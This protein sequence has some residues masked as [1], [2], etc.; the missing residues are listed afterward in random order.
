RGLDRDR[1]LSKALSLGLIDETEIENLKEEEVWNFIFQPGFSTSEKVTDISGRGVGL[2]I[3]HR[4]ILKLNGDIE[5]KTRSGNGTTFFLKLPLTIA[6][7]EGMV[8]KYRDIS[9]I[10]P[11]I[12]V[13]ET[14]NLKELK[15][16]E[17]HEEKQ[18]IRYRNQLVPVINL[19]KLLKKDIVSENENIIESLYLIIVEYRD[20]CLG[21]IFDEIVGNQSVVIKPLPALIED[22]TGFSGCTILG[23]GKIGMI[24]DIKFLIN[25]YYKENKKTELVYE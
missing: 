7:I 11:T 16:E 9:Y 24:L 22:T 18:V 17:I 19:E 20:H 14:L 4:N 10:I 25:N 6:I 12:E 21:I 15:I 1:I 23:S 13:K 3:V 5:V 8:V 2:D